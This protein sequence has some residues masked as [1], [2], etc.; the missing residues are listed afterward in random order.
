MYH[1]YQ[2]QKFNVFLIYIRF[3]HEGWNFSSR[4]KTTVTNQKCILKAGKN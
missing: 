3:T 1:H 2:V 4:S